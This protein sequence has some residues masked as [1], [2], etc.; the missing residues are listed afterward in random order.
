MPGIVQAVR[1][2][3]TF[4]VCAHIFFGCLT[5]CYISRIYLFAFCLPVRMSR[6]E[7]VFIASP[8]QAK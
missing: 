2:A 5:V 8:G 7:I 3:H 6:K 4:H 1:Y